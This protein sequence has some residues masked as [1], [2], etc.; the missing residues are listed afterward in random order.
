MVDSTAAGDSFN[1]GYLAARLPAPSRT[2]PPP[3]GHRI[4]ARVIAHPGAIIPAAAMADLMP[5]STLRR[6]ARRQSNGDHLL[7]LL[8]QPL[9]ADPHHAA[10]LEEHRLGLG[11]MP[12]PGGVPV[13]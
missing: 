4:A 2:R 9:D 13:R 11:P 1:A 6:P 12:T 7:A 5:R 8:A 10:G 3:Q